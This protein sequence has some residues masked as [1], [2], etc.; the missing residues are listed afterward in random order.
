MSAYAP[1]GYSLFHL[2]FYPTILQNRIY[3]STVKNE[4]FIFTAPNHNLT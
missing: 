4:I 1:I 2:L 3:L